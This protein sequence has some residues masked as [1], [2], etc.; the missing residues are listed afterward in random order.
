MKPLTMFQR[1]VL[2]FMCQEERLHDG[3]RC[4]VTRASIEW[5]LQFSWQT[6]YSNAMLE[7]KDL[8]WLEVRNY[9]GRH[10][11]VLTDTGRSHMCNHVEKASRLVMVTNDQR[12]KKMEGFE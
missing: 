10:M 8:G 6:Y 11:Y 3:K 7:L 9:W 12:V 1:A 4:G 5:A 2:M